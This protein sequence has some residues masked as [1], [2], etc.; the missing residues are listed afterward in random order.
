MRLEEISLLLGMSRHQIRKIEEEK[1]S[2]TLF[3][4]YFLFL[5]KILKLEPDKAISELEKIA[6]KSTAKNDVR[7][8]S[9][10]HRQRRSSDTGEH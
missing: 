8:K 5:A 4:I 10:H 2:I 1:K 9:G 7:H 6:K 3:V